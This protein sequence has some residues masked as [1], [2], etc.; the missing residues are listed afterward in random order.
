MKK[1]NTISISVR[2]HD[3]EMAAKLVDYHLAALLDRM[4]SETKRVALVN[5][6]Y[7][8]EQVVKYPDPYVKQKI[9]NLIMEQVETSMMAEV[10]ENFAFKVVDPAREPDRKVWPLRG[11][12]VTLSFVASLVIGIL[13]VFVSE[14]FKK[15]KENS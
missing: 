11:L 2:F 4:T 5:M 3:P 13:A 14:Y 15:M 12:M 1:E 7:L 8:E 9:F 6:K 10:K